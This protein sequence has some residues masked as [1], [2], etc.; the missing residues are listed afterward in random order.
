MI[1]LNYSEKL[2]FLLK[3]DFSEQELLR[4]LDRNGYKKR[5]CIFLI[6]T[7]LFNFKTQLL[8]DKF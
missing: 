1:I 7:F 5:A 3:V 4:T 2:A 8:Y 6:L